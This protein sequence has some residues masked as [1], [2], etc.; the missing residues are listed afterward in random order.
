[1]LI[2]LQKPLKIKNTIYNSGDTI[3]LEETYAN[4]LIAKGLAVKQPVEPKQKENIFIKLYGTDTVLMGKLRTEL[5]KEFLSS[6][7]KKYPARPH[8]DG[9]ISTTCLFCGGNLFV[10]NFTG[11][12]YCFNCKQEQP[13]EYLFEI[14]KG[15]DIYSIVQEIQNQQPKRKAMR[16]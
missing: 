9:Y 8:P 6:L 12:T 16:W 11:T 5:F 1:M 2:E 10:N 3:D 14:L 15:C 4:I 13:F 7:N